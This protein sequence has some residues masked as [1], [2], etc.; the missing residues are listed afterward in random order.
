MMRP[1]AIISS[2]AIEMAL[3]RKLGVILC[4]NEGAS[5]IAG[6]VPMPKAIIMSVAVCAL[7]AARARDRAA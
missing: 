6:I 3:V 5:I 4:N 2:A 1:M 7:L